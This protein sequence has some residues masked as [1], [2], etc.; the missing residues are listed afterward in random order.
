MSLDLKQNYF[1]LFALSIQFELDKIALSAAFLQLQ[2]QWH[3]DR[4]AC[5]SDAERRIS[6]QNTSFINTAHTTLSCPRLRAR[7]LLEL[8]NISFN[9]EVE[10]SQD[11]LFLM[12]QMELRESIEEVTDADDPLDALDQIKADVKQQR[13]ALEDAFQQHYLD[14]QWFEAK[15]LVLKMRFMERVFSEIQRLEEKLED[16]FF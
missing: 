15:Q 7:Y 2:H 5:G 14:Q 12:Q 11:S 1:D 6:M 3:P 9:D 4:F 16:E 10:T 13:L 8:A